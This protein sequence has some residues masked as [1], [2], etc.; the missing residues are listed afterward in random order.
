MMVG[1]LDARQCFTRQLIRRTV[2]SNQRITS[3]SFYACL[4]L[5]GILFK[6][7]GDWLK[8]LR[9]VNLSYCQHVQSRHIMKLI[10]S[11]LPLRTLNLSYTGINRRALERL[12]ELEHL[13]D[14][15]LKGCFDIES[16]DMFEFLLTGL[17]PRLSRLNLSYLFTVQG[18]WLVDMSSRVKLE[19]L[20]VRCAEYITRSDVRKIQ[21][22]WGNKCQVL[23][24]AKL[25]TD[26]EQGWIQF[27]EE[28]VEADVVR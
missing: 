7:F 15:S 8:N 28:L 10:Q 3:I 9:H 2:K 18:E 21:E 19:L 27:V 25:E 20:D 22:R 14:L 26:D 17:P 1:R 16:Q 24:T 5:S 12:H 23:A 13:T 4:D 6:F 11:R